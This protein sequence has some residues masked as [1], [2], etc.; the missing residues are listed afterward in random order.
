MQLLGLT[1]YPIIP[2]NPQ[3][4]GDQKY[5]NWGFNTHCKFI[6]TVFHLEKQNLCVERNSG[7]VERRTKNANI[8]KRHVAGA[9]IWYHCWP[10]I[11]LWSTLVHIS[12]L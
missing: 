3:E 8:H 10:A 9:L 7:V 5:V 1:Q 12:H 6:T 4:Q 11:R 2:R